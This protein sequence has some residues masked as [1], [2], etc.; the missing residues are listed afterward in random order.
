MEV[1]SSLRILV[2]EMSSSQRIQKDIYWQLEGVG[3]TTNIFILD[4]PDIGLSFSG[5]IYS[6]HLFY[7]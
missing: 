7:L 4:N 2:V 3:S 1:V 5:K 6:V